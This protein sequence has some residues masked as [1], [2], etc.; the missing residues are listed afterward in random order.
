MKVAG[1]EMDLSDDK[2]Q[3]VFWTR[4]NPYCWSPSNQ[5]QK[6]MNQMEQRIAPPKDAN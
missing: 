2:C 1:Y 3:I 6:W 4:V 5:F